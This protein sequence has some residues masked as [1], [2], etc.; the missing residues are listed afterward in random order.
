MKPTECEVDGVKYEAIPVPAIYGCDGCEGD[1]SID[2]CMKLM[3]DL[4]GGDCVGVIWIKKE[5]Q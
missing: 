2:L 4:H 1:Q 5:P 3:V